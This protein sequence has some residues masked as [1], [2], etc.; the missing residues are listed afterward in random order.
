M[1]DLRKETF[2]ALFDG[3]ATDFETK[4]ILQNLTPQEREAWKRYQVMRMA[5]TERLNEK[6]LS[7]DVSAAVSAAIADDAHESPTVN[8]KP[9][10]W[11]RPVTHLH[12]L[13]PA[14]GF[15]AAASVAFF[16]VIGIEN[17][18]KAFVA[19]GDVSSSRLPMSVEPGLRAVNAKVSE[20]SSS[21]S[22]SSEEEQ[23]KQF[24]DFYIEHF[25]R[26]GEK[27]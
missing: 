2:S 27:Q 19:D 24:N 3:E 23:Q 11:K 7:F 12:W 9:Q 8:S 25:L 18:D 5:M 14:A 13:K 26:G 20:K 10:F 22:L 1:S 6:A 16:V 4:R 17:S 15:A 21:E